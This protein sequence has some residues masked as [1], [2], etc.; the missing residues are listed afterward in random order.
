M[1]TDT[2]IGQLGMYF[3]NRVMA[4]TLCCGILVLASSDVNAKII[5]SG[6]LEKRNFDA[7]GCSVSSMSVKYSFSILMG[8]PVVNGVFKW[9][10]SGDTEPDCL[11]TAEIYVQVSGGGLS[12]YIPLQGVSPKAGE[13]Y[14]MN[15]GG[16][17][18]WNNAIC[19]LEGGNC[20]GE[21]LA[22]MLWKNMNVNGFEVRAT[23]NQVQG[24]GEEQQTDDGFWSDGD[25]SMLDYYVKK[26][27]ERRQFEEELKKSGLSLGAG[28]LQITLTWNTSSD[29][30]LYVTEPGGETM[31]Y[32]HKNSFAGGKLDV[33]DTDGHGPENVFWPTG[34]TP[35]GT[36]KVKVKYYGGSGATNYTVRVLKAGQVLFYRGTLGRSG[37]ED[38]VTSIS[39][40][41]LTG[42][43]CRPTFLPR[44]QEGI[45]LY[46]CPDCSV[47]EVATAFNAQRQRTYNGQ[48]DLD[49]VLGGLC[50]GQVPPTEEA[51]DGSEEGGTGHNNKPAGDGF[52]G[53]Q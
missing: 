35:E 17:P 3:S 32:Q 6:I 40:Q 21:G 24:A 46:Q 22:K 5:A 14:G 25:N 23:A 28:D 45:E 41:K 33:D 20:L 42:R 7:S 53:L 8:E 18:N 26:E 19:G 44:K 50:S 1:F 48:I 15:V 43:R 13:G 37:D 36:F 16:S 51:Q 47:K 9:E 2:F 38:E 29:I 27:R 39:M 11:A 49:R 10:A 30:D 52:W 12:G 34:R 31:S 4:V